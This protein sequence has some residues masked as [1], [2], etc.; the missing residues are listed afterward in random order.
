MALVLRKRD[1]GVLSPTSSRS[2]LEQDLKKLDGCCK[3]LPTT[4]CRSIH[5]FYLEAAYEISLLGI[6]NLHNVCIA[7]L[8]Q[9]VVTPIS[10]ILT[11]E[12]GVKVCDHLHSAVTL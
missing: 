7:T 1:S 12:T 4:D 5:H 6:R 2:T 3:S 10:A 9:G 11:S 8:C